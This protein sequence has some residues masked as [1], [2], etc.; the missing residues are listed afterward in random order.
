MAVN[1][2]GQ[3]A[4]MSTAV[5]DF[6]LI[7]PKDGFKHLKWPMFKP[8]LMQ[9]CNSGYRAFQEAHIKMDSIRQNTERIPDG[10]KEIVSILV[11]G[12][13]ETVKAVLPIALENVKSIADES[14]R[15]AKV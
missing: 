14:L 13:A 8:N 7:E 4:L 12:E 2:L 1:A 15:S 10:M 6:D 5:K 3:L 9:I 11:K